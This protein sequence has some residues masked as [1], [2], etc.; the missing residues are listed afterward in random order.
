MGF[1]K[2]AA[3]LLGKPVLRRTLEAF[4]M[5]DSISS[6]VVV[7]PEE[8]WHLL[9]PTDF[10]K[11]VTRTD[12]GAD[13]QDSVAM[14]LRAVQGSPDF[15][16]VHDAA[17]PLVS[18]ADINRAVTEAF[19]EDAVSLARRVTETVKRSNDHNLC[20]EAVSRQNLW[21]METPQVFARNLLE[22]ACRHIAEN[23]I[24]VTDEVSA[25]ETISIR[26][27]FIESTS[28]NPKITTPAD[29][30]LAEALWKSKS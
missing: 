13:R 22:E 19:A 15:I 27:R 12:G 5:A 18:P 28:P 10:G 29:L 4:L 2:L 26:A 24:T 20:M 14:G 11:P 21:F 17:R 8:R 16:A 6:I 3:D 1:D 25:L 30:A 9:A 23:R 7:C